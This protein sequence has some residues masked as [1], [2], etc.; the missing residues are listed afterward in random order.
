MAQSP[1]MAFIGA[2]NMSGAIIDGLLASGVDPQ[3]LRAS[4]SSQQSLAQW[5]NKGLHTSTDNLSLIPGADVIVLGVKPQGLRAVCEQIA[6]QVRQHKPLI[7][8]VAAGVSLKSLENW[9]GKDLA[10]VRSMPNTPS[11]LRCGATGLIANA[12]VTQTQREHTQ[13]ILSAVGICCWVNNEAELDAVIAVSGS[14]PA[15]FFLFV[16][17]MIKAGEKLGLNHDVATEL[18]NQT[19]LGAARMLTESGK[20][21]ATLRRQVTS[22]GG[23]TAQAI[24]TF[25]N[26]AL[27][28]TVE[29]AMR[30]AVARAQTMSQELS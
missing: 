26:K 29:D 21:A 11:Q 14:G 16:E 23:T 9:L 8:S 7:I 2:G 15:Y 17:A 6:A 18:A 19:A 1:N 13:A 4:T 30:A 28:Q 10:I 3:Y 22:P 12:A 5:Q 24:A 25:E 20:D 27:H